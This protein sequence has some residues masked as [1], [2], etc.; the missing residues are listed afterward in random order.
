MATH[1][2]TLPHVPPQPSRRALLGGLAGAAASVTVAPV[3]AEAAADP[4]LAWEAELP[5]LRAACEAAEGREPDHD[6]ACARLWAMGDRILLT[7]ATTPAGI[8]TQVRGVLASSCHGELT[9]EDQEG[10][11]NAVRSLSALAGV[12]DGLPLEEDQ[13]GE[14]EEEQEAEQPPRPWWAERALPGWVALS[15][16]YQPGA[17]DPEE[18]QK[19]VGR[20]TVGELAFAAAMLRLICRLDGGAA[21]VAQ[22]PRELVGK[23]EECL[24]QQL[25]ECAA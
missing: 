7:P 19:L 11:K 3:A 5:A 17:Y 25:Q 2:D 14:Q 13:G 22:F 4:H 10:L 15:E 16:S 6:D 12:P 18:M 9:D 24:T 21:I 1:I 23:A 20:T 8:A